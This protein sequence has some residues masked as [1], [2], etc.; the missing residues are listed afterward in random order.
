MTHQVLLLDANAAKQKI[1]RLAYEIYENHIKSKSILLI[2]IAEKGTALAKLL[3]Q[4]IELIC[5]LEITVLKLFIDKQ[6]PIDCHLAIEAILDN[7]SIILVDDVA[8]SGRTLLYALKPLMQSLP[9]QI[10]IAVLVDRKHKKYPITADYIGIQLS[11]TLQENIN[12]EFKNGNIS[13]ASIN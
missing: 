3:K 9:S 5:D 8:N 12:V 11:T 2:G 13:K 7:K 1:I 4:Q 6:N 10:Q